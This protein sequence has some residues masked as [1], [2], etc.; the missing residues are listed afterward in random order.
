MPDLASA[1]CGF[2]GGRVGATPHGPAL[3]LLNDVSDR[4]RLAVLSRPMDVN[5]ASHGDGEVRAE[6]DDG[7]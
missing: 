4:A 2:T 6:R 7:A 5:M 3:L 1:G